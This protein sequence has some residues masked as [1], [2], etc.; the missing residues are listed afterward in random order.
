MCVSWCADYVT[1]T[2]SLSNVS[3]L[4][5]SLDRSVT[6]KDKDSYCISLFRLMRPIDQ[7]FMATL[8]C[9]QLITKGVKIGVMKIDT[10]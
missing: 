9:T 8:F 1:R 2:F 3:V 5:L 10:G 4:R 7:K 6:D